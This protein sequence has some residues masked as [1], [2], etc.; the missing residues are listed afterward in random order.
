M[1]LL[2]Q[3]FKPFTP[4]VQTQFPP[5]RRIDERERLRRIILDDEEWL[6][7]HEAKRKPI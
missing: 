6:V 5:K 2:L 4:Q 7:L 1:L 3:G